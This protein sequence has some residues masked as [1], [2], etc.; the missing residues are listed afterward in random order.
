[1]ART[2]QTARK[3]TGGKAPRKALATK[4]CTWRHGPRFIGVPK[5]SGAWTKDSLGQRVDSRGY[6]DEED[7]WERIPK[8]FIVPNHCAIVQRKRLREKKRKA[9]GKR[10]AERTGHAQSPL[11]V[12]PT[13][14]LVEIL[15]P[16]I[17]TGAI[18]HFSPEVPIRGDF[19][20]LH[21]VQLITRAGDSDTPADEA[22][23][24]P[25]P[26]ALVSKR[27]KDVAYGIFYGQ[28]QFVLEVCGFDG[29]LTSHVAVAYEDSEDRAANVSCGVASWNKIVPALP[30]D[31]SSPLSR[32]AM[33]Y[34]S[35]LTICVGLLA[36][37]VGE[38][39][40]EKDTIREKLELI[41]AC[42]SRTK[43]PRRLA[44][45]VDFLKKSSGRI[46]SQQLVL[47]TLDSV[48]EMG[49]K[50]STKTIC[51]EEA[52]ETFQ[53]AIEVLGAPDAQGNL[54]LLQS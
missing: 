32:V 27:L 18:Y 22:S 2:K 21:S 43:N 4:S 46:I 9:V 49:L 36:P 7:P 20:R 40:S 6:E 35:D 48:F 25:L 26:I 33:E 16:L 37:A 3:S 12:L 38:V 11:E 10:T 47:G 50:K 31:L 42:F 5:K 52:S 53:D 51:S 19:Q 54:C 45:R 14:L 29:G 15:S 44:I 39:Y 17:R 8:V 23:R 34:V 30:A 28:N 1:M 13:E 24:S 41:S